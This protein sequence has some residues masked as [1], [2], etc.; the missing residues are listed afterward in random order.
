MSDSLG[1][2]VRKLPHAKLVYHVTVNHFRY[3]I[4]MPRG[5]PT[6]QSRSRIP[7]AASSATGHAT[8]ASQ[9]YT[10]AS[11][12]SNLQNIILLRSKRENNLVRSGGVCGGV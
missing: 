12:L 1:T 4:E 2:S 6:H 11:F 10:R 5:M 8:T 7:C 3:V 9:Q